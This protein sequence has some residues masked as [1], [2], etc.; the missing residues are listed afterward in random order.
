MAEPGKTIKG[1]DIYNLIQAAKA[2]GVT[3]SS[4]ARELKDV[5]VQTI[6]SPGPGVVKQATRSGRKKRR[7]PFRE[8][9][10]KWREQKK[11]EL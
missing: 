10:R 5:T 6:V 11:Q 2:E 9:D 3:I 8:Q 7:N 4:K 1:E